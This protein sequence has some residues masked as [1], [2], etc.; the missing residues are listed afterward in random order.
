LNCFTA[1]VEGRRALGERR[2]DELVQIFIGSG[3]HVPSVELKVHCAQEL[4]KKKPK[5]CH[6]VL[7]RIAAIRIARRRAAKAAADRARRA[8]QA[9]HKRKRDQL[10]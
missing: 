5:L 3:N 2:V 10:D 7:D 9:E 1:R 4:F 8:R 6:E